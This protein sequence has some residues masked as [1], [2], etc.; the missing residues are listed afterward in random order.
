M[1]CVGTCAVSAGLPVISIFPG[2]DRAGLTYSAPAGLK[3]LL[4]RPVFVSSLVWRE[5]ACLERSRRAADFDSRFRLRGVDQN[6][7]PC[8]KESGLLALSKPVCCHRGGTNLAEVTVVM[9]L[10][11]NTYVLATTHPDGMY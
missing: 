1:S 6:L 2:T 11:H 4:D 8:R 9:T 10:K 7:H 5:G 3:F